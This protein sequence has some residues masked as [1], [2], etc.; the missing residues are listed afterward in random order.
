MD[1]ERMPANS[2]Y[3]RNRVARDQDPVRTR[4]E[5]MLVNEQSLFNHT[6]MPPSNYLVAN[7]S[8]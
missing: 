4:K 1:L 7:G 6:S 8:C 5:Q 2:V 3:H